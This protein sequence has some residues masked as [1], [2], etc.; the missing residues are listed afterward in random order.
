MSEL[1]LP[2]SVSY[3]F[4]MN[5]LHLIQEVTKRP[6]SEILIFFYEL[7]N[8]VADIGAQDKLA[9]GSTTGRIQKNIVNYFP[10]T[11]V[12]FHLRVKGFR[13]TKSDY[14]PITRC[15]EN[16]EA[17]YRCSADLSFPKANTYMNEEQLRSIQTALM[18]K[19]LLGGENVELPPFDK[20]KIKTPR[21][22]KALMEEFTKTNENASE[23]RTAE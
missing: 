8:Q 9:E 17:V 12:P 7:I 19:A 21:M 16:L 3:K 4:D 18:E 13:S 15:Y 11:S 1:D 10:G 14:N 5:L 23:R 22:F 2:L 6:T 20:P